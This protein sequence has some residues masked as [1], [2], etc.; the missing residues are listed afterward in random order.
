MSQHFLLSAKARTLSLA[1]VMRMTDAQAETT[2]RSV[3]WP[4]GKAVCP[5][6]ECPTV[7]ECRRPDG[8]L[9]FRCKA[10]RKDFSITS[11]TLF[12]FHKKGLRDYLA[13]IVIFTNECKGK[14]A[15]AMSRDLD[16]QYKTAFV[17]GHKL[18]EAMASELKG[19]RLG[20][21][22]ETVEVDCG[23]FGGYVK[24]ANHK[25]NRRDRRLAKN[26]NGK[27]QVVV[28]MRERGGRTL[29]SVFKSETAALSFIVNRVAPETNL[30][31]D[32]ATSWND[33][34]TRYEVS[35]I[36]HGSLYSDRSGVY[37]NGAEEFFSRMRRAEIGHHHH[38]AGQ[39]LI[40]YAQESAWREDHRRVAN[41]TQ[42]RMV[43]GLAMAAPTSV[44]W[45]GYW[46][47]AQKAA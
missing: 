21:A 1:E 33:L 22:G 46:Q 39:Y 47:R 24:P 9:R 44:D 19:M 40:R 6:C 32:E 17:L 12:A 26:Q 35:R 8:A 11:G 38:I 31:A 30:M 7:Y 16:C 43:A 13:A 3:R 10:C 45:C 20:G 15:L 27:R 23:Y 37:T 36:D 41:G 29:P 18:R 14:S 25:E 5:H 42:V 4:D 28:V 2:F 34:H